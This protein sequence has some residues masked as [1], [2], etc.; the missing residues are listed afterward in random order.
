MIKENNCCLKIFGFLVISVAS[1]GAIIGIFADPNKLELVS[2]YSRSATA[3]N[4]LATMVKECFVKIADKGS[5]TVIVPELQGY[6]PKKNNIA[7][8]YLGNNRKLSGTSIDCPTTGEM[9]VVSE[10]E[11]EYPTFSYNFG[12]GEK[13]CIA[14]SGSD[15]EKRGCINGE[16]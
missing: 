2:E 5:G 16:W 10:D 8:F 11:S 9:K 13:T 7:G 14:D 1:A 6:K 3:A 15:A 4:T 12:T